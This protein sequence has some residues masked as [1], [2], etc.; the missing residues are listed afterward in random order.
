M[1]TWQYPMYQYTIHDKRRMLTFTEKKDKITA[2]STRSAFL[3]VA[4]YVTVANCGV[5]TY[6]WYSVRHYFLFPP[7]IAKSSSQLENPSE[8]QIAAVARRLHPQRICCSSRKYFHEI[9][10]AKDSDGRGEGRY[11]RRKI[12]TVI[13]NRGEVQMRARA[14]LI[15]E[16]G[17]D[18]VFFFFGVTRHA[19]W[20]NRF[21][22]AWKSSRVSGR[23]IPALMSY[24]HPASPDRYLCHFRRCDRHYF[25]PRD[26]SSSTIIEENES[27]SIPFNRVP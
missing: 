15:A 20:R 7:I 3:R 13:M 19:T 22:T 25:I 11:E 9:L 6:T 26:S 5:R 2:V 17:R 16:D 12:Y 23:L 18:P 4:V 1:V 10:S 8:Q 27:A 24:K 14:K 21:L